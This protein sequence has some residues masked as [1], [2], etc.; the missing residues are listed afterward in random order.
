MVIRIRVSGVTTSITTLTETFSFLL[1]PLFS[2]PFSF[3]SVT[4][5]DTKHV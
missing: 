2:Y 5:F 1:E 4:L 3:K